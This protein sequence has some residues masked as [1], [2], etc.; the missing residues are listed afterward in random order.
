MNY[1]ISFEEMS[2]LAA[3]QDKKSLSLEEMREQ[4]ARLK[5]KSKSD[6]KKKK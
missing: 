6:K 1:H 2:K 3:Q 5:D 4:V